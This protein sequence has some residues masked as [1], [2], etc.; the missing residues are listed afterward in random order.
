MEGVDQNRGSTHAI[1]GIGRGRTLSLAQGCPGDL[2]AILERAKMRTGC[3]AR[4]CKP[5]GRM[6]FVPVEIAGNWKGRD[7]CFGKGADHRAPPQKRPTN[8]AAIKERHSQFSPMMMV[9]AIGQDS[10]LADERV[11][12]GAE[13]LELRRN[14]RNRTTARTERAI[15]WH[16]RA[17]A[18]PSRIVNPRPCA[19]MRRR[20]DRDRRN[21]GPAHARQRSGVSAGSIT[22]SH[23]PAASRIARLICASC[24]GV[25]GG[26]AMR[27]GP[28]CAIGQAACLG[29]ARFSTDGTAMTVAS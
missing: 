29:D 28:T 2:V 10:P 21:S 4:A 9:V 22:A 6:T 26:M 7:R 3:P 20:P 23:R 16:R 1:R 18:S 15:D 12:L 19:R 5:S 11:T 13:S 17:S 8:G 27:I 14:G 25:S 24:S